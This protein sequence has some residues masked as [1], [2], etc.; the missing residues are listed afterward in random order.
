M[1]RS[2]LPGPPGRPGR[3]ERKEVE[4]ERAWTRQTSYV[5]FLA[6]T[7][8]GLAH[9]LA[10]HPVGAVGPACEVLHFAPLAAERPPRGID[11]LAPAEDA[12]GRLRRHH[13]IRPAILSIGMY[14]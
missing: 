8:I 5:R 4:P 9:R 13:S 7:F 14:A 10:R 12:Q 3:S 2:L 11:R 1:W 6:F